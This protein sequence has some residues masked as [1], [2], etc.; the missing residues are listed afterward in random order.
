M[1]HRLAMRAVLP[2]VALAL[3]GSVPAHAVVQPGGDAPTLELSPARAPGGSVVRASGDGYVPGI[4]VRIELDGARV[5]ESTADDDG[6]I[7]LAVP[8]PRGNATELEAQTCSVVRVEG[9]ERCDG[10]LGA[11]AELFRLDPPQVRVAPERAEPAEKVL[12]STS[13]FAD[14]DL[15]G[16]VR[17]R[18]GGQLVATAVPTDGNGDGGFDATLAV[19]VPSTQA[20]SLSAAQ[21]RAA[22]SLAA[23][24]PFTV[25][26]LAVL[27]QRVAAGSTVIVQGSGFP[28]RCGPVRLVVAGHPVADVVPDARG[29]FR[30]RVPVPAAAPG[31]ST[32]VAEQEEGDCEPV[33]LARGLTVVPVVVATASAAHGTTPALPSSRADLALDRTSAGPGDDV[34]VRGTGWPASTD[35]ALMLDGKRLAV[36]RTAAD[37]TF[38]HRFRAPEEPARHIVEGCSGCGSRRERAALVAFSVEAVPWWRDAR[39]AGAALLGVLLLLSALAAAGRTPRRRQQAAVCVVPVPGPPVRVRVDSEDVPSTVRLVVRSGT[40]SHAVQEVV[41]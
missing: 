22:C 5:G 6:R 10:E 41:P 40:V 39:L 12:V 35:V 26:R 2:V 11:T 17:V 36:V 13:G 20:G 37:G 33:R 34:V 18:V 25:L 16:P 7:S 30:R 24:A 8:V 32:V 31:R 38:A 27:P 29:G 3:G 28:D 23:T 4:T 19:G 1:R 9:G 14:P 21:E 15:C